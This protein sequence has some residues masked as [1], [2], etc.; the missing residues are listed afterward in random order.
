MAPVSGMARRPWDTDRRLRDREYSPSLCVDDLNRFL[1]EY[2]ARSAR[3]RASLPWTEH[4][5]GP[6]PAERLYFFPAARAGA[7]ARAP[8]HVFVH[9]GY[10]QELSKEDSCFAAPDF[11]RRGAAFAAIG[12]GL[13][14]A[15]RLDEIVAMVRSGVLWLYRNAGELGVDPGRIFLSG[16]SAGAH[17]V[18]MCLMD[19]WLPGSLRVTD[20]VQGAALLSGLYELEP[21]RQTYVGDAIGLTAAEAAR[22][23]PV[24][25]L[26]ADIPPLIVARGENEPTAFGDQQECFTGALRAVGVPVTDLV[27]APRNHFDVPF[28]LG[29]TESPLGRATLAAMRL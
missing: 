10:W 2:A 3:A 27:V 4:A 13:A 21:L 25:H 9:G 6:A 26:H 24:R 11:V 20:V 14:P 18:A 29:D 12:Y 16:S 5:Y 15:H 7:D 28:D 8:L 22:N 23:S 1:R 19:G 17:L